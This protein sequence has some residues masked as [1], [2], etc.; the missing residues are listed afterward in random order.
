MYFLFKNTLS[1]NFE[2]VW[3]LNTSSKH[4]LINPGQY[5]LQKQDSV[6]CIFA[7]PSFQKNLNHKQVFT[8]ENYNKLS[9]V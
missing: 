7:P 4:T 3:K 1:I 9:R 8:M 5:A 6:I 2:K